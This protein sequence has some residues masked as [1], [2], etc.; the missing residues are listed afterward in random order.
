MSRWTMDH[1]SVG[2]KFG[3]LTFIEL[4][5]LR[6]ANNHRLGKWLCDCK[7]EK[8][9]PIS[10]VMT[11]YIRSCGCLMRESKPALKHGMKGTPE[12]HSWI[13]MNARCNNKKHKDYPRYGAKGITVCQEWRSS[14]ERFFADVGTRPSTPLGVM[15]LVDYAATL[16]ISRGAAHLRLKRG[17]L[18]GC[19]LSCTSAI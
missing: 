18:D 5:P 2:Q 7:S 6:S 11:G 16:G 17:K 8:V 4:M 3:R 19:T 13:A 14:F 1:L 10:R 9:I 15:L 12:Y